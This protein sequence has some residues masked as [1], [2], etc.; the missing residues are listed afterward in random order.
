MSW[1]QFFPLGLGSFTQIAPSLVKLVLTSD[2]FLAVEE[3]KIIVI[4]GFF[5]SIDRYR[6]KIDENQSKIDKNQSE[7]DENQSNINKNQSKIDENNQKLT[8][9]ECKIGHLSSIFV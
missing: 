6:L 5:L 1:G 2:N 9:I 4:A 8:K 7:I 3:K